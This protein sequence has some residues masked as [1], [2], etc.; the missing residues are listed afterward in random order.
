MAG[1]LQLPLH[2]KIMPDSHPYPLDELDK[3]ATKACSVAFDVSPQCQKKIFLERL[4]L[5][6]KFSSAEYHDSVLVMAK[7][8]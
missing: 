5:V 4:D 1:P 8:R 2:Y 6:R 3:T 7:L